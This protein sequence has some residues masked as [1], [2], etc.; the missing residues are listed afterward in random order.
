MRGRMMCLGKVDMLVDD[1][2]NQEKAKAVVSN[3]QNY[4]DKTQTPETENR[5]DVA[6]AKDIIT[7]Y[8]NNNEK[9]TCPAIM[10][11]APCQ[12]TEAG[13]RTCPPE[14]TCP[15]SQPCPA[16]ANDDEAFERGYAAGLRDGKSTTSTPV[17]EEK[18]TD[19]EVESH[20]PGRPGFEETPV[21][22]MD[23]PEVKRSAEDKKIRDEEDGLID[24]EYIREGVDVS[25]WNCEQRVCD[26]KLEDATPVMLRGLYETAKETLD[27]RTSSLGS[28]LDAICSMKCVSRAART[29]EEEI[30]QYLSSYI[31]RRV[32]WHIPGKEDKVV[33]I[34]P[35]RPDVQAALYVVTGADRT[36]EMTE[37]DL[38]GSDLR[39]ADLEF[40]NLYSVN[41]SGS[42]LN[43]TNLGQAEGLDD[44]FKIYL[45]TIDETTRIPDSV[46]AGFVPT[47]APYIPPQEPGSYKVTTN[48]WIWWTAT[49]VTD[50]AKLAPIAPLRPSEMKTIIKP[51]APKV[52][53]V[54]EPPIE[55]KKAP[56]PE[57]NI[58]DELLLVPEDIETEM[59]TLE[60]VPEL[61]SV[62]APASELEVAPE[63]VSTDAGGEATEDDFV[64]SIDEIK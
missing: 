11:P 32:P 39:G 12:A 43:A 52:K 49:P 14:K 24:A 7:A 50:R 29:Q 55:L 25:S 21:A 63:P 42:N 6:A 28:R 15:A 56:A 5:S 47:K 20:R 13:Q 60:P 2:T 31:R 22:L 26:A 37:I 18:G 23:D 3:L 17:P 46:S 45:V 10:P 1:C 19:R 35:V 38:R 8:D 36:K 44:W 57:V 16:V 33:P 61:E 53:V 41:L 9:V 40:A 59:D 27:S 30:I 4:V 48:D 54:A 58:L 34:R 62:L 51:A 64:I